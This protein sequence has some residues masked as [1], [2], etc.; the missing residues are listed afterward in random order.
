MGVYIPDPDEGS[1]EDDKSE[2]FIE[3]VKT[4][5][6]LSQANI[7]SD[8][9]LDT[10]GK[11]KEVATVDSSLS[12]VNV[13]LAPGEESQPGGEEVEASGATSAGLGA[14]GG[15]DEI[16]RARQFRSREADDDR[17]EQNFRCPVPN[18]GRTFE[19]Q[20]LL[21]RAL[22]SL[23]IFFDRLLTLIIKPNRSHSRAR[24]SPVSL[25]HAWV[26]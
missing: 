3:S 15:L 8:R 2:A 25:P 18:C 12:R 19:K 11:G 20:Y 4:S 26:R 16:E 10:K 22:L 9:P 13:A 7:P 5:P 17:G 24:R 23:P 21:K 6:A 1:D 14:L